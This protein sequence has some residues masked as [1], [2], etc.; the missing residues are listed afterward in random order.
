M[1]RLTIFALGT[2]VALAGCGDD[3]STTD[4]GTV[5]DTGVVTDSGGG[6]D[7]GDTDSGSP[8]DAGD[9]DTGTATDAGDTDTGT[10]TDAG[11]G[12]DTGT[13]ASGDCIN[14]ADN[15]VAAATDIA[16]DAEACGRESSCLGGRDCVIDCMRDDVG[17][18]MACAV[19]FGDVAQCTRSN[20]ALRCINSSSAGC[21]SCRADNGCTSAFET[22]SGLPGS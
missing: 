17:V 9:T 8:T 22:C 15:A 18:T 13:A 3:S 2:L 6:T 12:T 19:C 7:G 14:P 16:A 21:I 11:G 1:L 4:S 20:C 5:A 10:A